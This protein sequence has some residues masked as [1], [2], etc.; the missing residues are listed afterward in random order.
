MVLFR[1]WGF[2]ED[3]KKMYAYASVNKGK[4][5]YAMRDLNTEELRVNEIISDSDRYDLAKAFSTILIKYE[6]GRVNPGEE[7]S[8]VWG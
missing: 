5:I 2:T 7:V 6:K 1:D 8:A 3:G 4:E